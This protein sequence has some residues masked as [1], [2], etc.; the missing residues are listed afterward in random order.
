MELQLF[1]IDDR[2]IHGQVVIGWA[3]HLNTDT[4]VLCDDSVVANEWEKELYLSIVPDHIKAFVLDV[5]HLAQEM[6][7]EKNDWGKTVILVNS[8]FTVEALFQQK[9]FVPE[10]NIGG[11]HFKDGRKELLPYLFLN[12]AEVDSFKRLMEQ[13]VVFFCQDVPTAKPVPLKNLIHK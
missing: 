2:L 9:V 10:I 11:I 13:G 12:E 8:P 5:D 7:N 4:I 1:R 6:K 3:Q